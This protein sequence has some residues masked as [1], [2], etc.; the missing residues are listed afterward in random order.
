M[1][2]A[3]GGPVT[4][5]PI[6]PQVWQLDAASLSDANKALRILPRELRPYAPRHPHGRSGDHSHGVGRPDASAR[7]LGSS[8][9]RATSWSSTPE[10][11]STQCLVNS[12]QPRHS[13]V[14]WPAS[15]STDL[16]RDTG[17]SRPAA[18]AHLLR[19]GRFHV[20]RERDNLP[21]PS[22]R[23]VLQASR[24]A[25][26]RSWWATTTASWSSAMRSW[27]RPLRRAEA[28]QRREGK[29]RAAIQDGTSLFEHL[30]FAEHV[31][32][33]QAGRPSSLAFTAE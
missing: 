7:R 24:S 8:A 25:P 16:C 18:A 5:K 2:T 15:S 28:I 12:S 22:S 30:N 10:R 17:D 21:L 4:S 1:N 19:S 23:S 29:V 13:G 31:E 20:P 32:N 27:R 26:A 33:L 11:P 9:A 6:P 14:R 3:S